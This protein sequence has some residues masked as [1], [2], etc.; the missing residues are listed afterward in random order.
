MLFQ[1]N[2]QRGFHRIFVILSV[3]YMVAVALFPFYEDKKEMD[4]Q[5]ARSISIYRSCMDAARSEAQGLSIVEGIAAYKA[6]N[7]EFDRYTRQSMS[8]ES[9][10]G[11]W[12]EGWRLLWIVPAV[13]LIPPLIVYGMIRF[14]VKIG[15]WAARGFMESRS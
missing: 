1:M 4:T 2:V 15:L 9:W 13:L 12:A 7:D 5:L 14:L 11:I 10:K 6:C 8:V 3:L